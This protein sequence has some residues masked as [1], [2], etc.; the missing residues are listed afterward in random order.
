VLSDGALHQLSDRTLTEYPRRERS[1][2]EAS[3]I[4]QAR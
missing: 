4:D 2:W 3:D 1:R